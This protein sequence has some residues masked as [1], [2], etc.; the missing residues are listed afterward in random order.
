[1]PS[2]LVSVGPN[3]RAGG[4]GSS[5]VEAWHREAIERVSVHGVRIC[6]IASRS[7]RRDPRA[8]AQANS[9]R[10][11]GHEVLG[12]STDESDFD[13]VTRVTKPSAYEGLRRLG[14]SQRMVRA[15]HATDADLYVPTGPNAEKTARS[16]AQGL[17]PFLTDPMAA[18]FEDS[19]NL[20]WRAPTDPSLSLPA[21]GE[22]PL[23][24]VPSYRHDPA[25]PAGS[26]AV[27]I[28]YRKT[29]RNPGRYLESALRRRGIETTHAESIVWDTISPRSL[30]V[31]VVESP[32]PALPV[33]GSNPGIPVVFWVHHGEHHLP[34]NLRLQRRYGAHAV[35]LAHSWHLAYRFGGLVDR[36]PFA[37]APEL[38]GSDFVPRGERRFD[39]AFVGSSAGGTR[40]R[41]R[42]QALESIAA[43]LGQERVA[44]AADVTPEEMMSLY[45]NS[46]IV[47]DDGAGRH[48][49]ITMR[50]FEAT[51]AGALL[52]TREAP[53]MEMLFRRDSEYI[54]M[55]GDGSDQ[56][57]QLAA[58]DT[59]SIARSGHATTWGQHTYEHR[60]DELLS[61]LART[62]DLEMSAPANLMP[63]SGLAGA[64]ASFCDAQRVL[65]LDAELGEQLGDREIWQFSSAADRAEPRTFN[66]AAIAGGSQA[67]RRR[68]VAAAR[69][70]VVTEPGLA[71]EI[72]DLVAAEHGE[73]HSLSLNQ[74]VVFTFGGS[75]YRVSSAPDP[76]SNA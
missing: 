54:P 51:G 68:A 6:L 29:N 27:H 24:H 40:Y 42:N 31:V 64:V 14:T 57:I 60:V 76:Q 21:R 67:D 3:P 12:V 22:P 59:E 34:T 39:V 56:I 43:K 9:T 35:A 1:M 17:A 33:L 2:R 62:R 53:G 13:W 70:A 32:L 26:G 5:T 66:L 4:D 65:T 15:A 25:S 16:A 75:G 37:L 20:I 7:I 52:V 63:P 58:S 38:T 45:R 36:I 71:V 18:E 61:L 69:T 30:G 41:R 46:R 72:E 73:H 74:S 55:R 8:V 48:L 11:A 44:I 10:A 47:P 50:V 49:P 19:Q 23:L 28:V